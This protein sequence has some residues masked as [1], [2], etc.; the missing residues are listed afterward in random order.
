M[1]DELFGYHGRYLRVD[2]SQRTARDVG[3]PVPVLREFIG[4]S[5]LG[6]WILQNE[7]DGHYDACLPTLR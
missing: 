3:L 4:G 7:T 1:T 6:T 5:G 2:L